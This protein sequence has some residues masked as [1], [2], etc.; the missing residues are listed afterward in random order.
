MSDGRSDVPG[1]RNSPPLLTQGQGPVLR[2]A[3][4]PHGGFFGRATSMNPSCNCPSVLGK[5]SRGDE[6]GAVVVHATMAAG[7]A[8]EFQWCSLKAKST[9]TRRD[10]STSNLSP[11]PFV[12]TKEKLP[13]LD[14][15]KLCNHHSS[16]ELPIP[17]H[18]TLL[19]PDLLLFS[20]PSSTTNNKTMLAVFFPAEQRFH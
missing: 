8:G 19:Q 14:W 2:A 4:Q 12:A 20:S 10:I 11:S 3:Q 15:L 9:G 7:P 16:K 17:C 6:R 5:R 13:M 18:L 1:A